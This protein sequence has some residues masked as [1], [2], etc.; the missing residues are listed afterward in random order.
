MT[1]TTANKD[2]EVFL[3]QV[4]D[5][6]EDV[7]KAIG[8]FI[9]KST[10]FINDH[11]TESGGLIGGLLGGP[12]GMVFG[13]LAGHE[14]EGRFHDA[15]SHINEAWETASETIR[16]SIGAILGDPL[17]MSS[18]A[19]R[20]RD[21][22]EQLGQVRNDIDAAN[23]YLSKTWTGRAYTAYENTSSFQLKAVQGMADTLAEA[24]DL[25]D[26]HQV[27]LLKYWTAQLKNLVDL[28]AAILGKAGELGDVGNW[29]TGGAGVVVQIIVT[30]GSEAASILQEAVDYW[31]DLNVGSAG[32]WDA[33]QSKL[34]QRGFEGDKWP[35]F[36]NVDLPNLNGPW[37][38]A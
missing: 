1:D 37:Q 3:T 13:G 7:N 17:R 5:A 24:A 11:L 23:R 32:D 34:G 29:F 22:V 6:I 25:L 30:A 10:N 8:D 16:Q 4:N 14:L 21:S 2:P 35:D 28:A 31:I 12:L 19:S 18:I 27:N 33:I 9:E 26:D 20:Y 36:S 15:I 38:H